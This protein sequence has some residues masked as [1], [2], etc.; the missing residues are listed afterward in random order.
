M[1]TAHKTKNN[2]TNTPTPDRRG[3]NPNRIRKPTGD[4]DF[5]REHIKS[6]PTIESHYC[7][8][9]TKRE[10]LGSHLSVNKMFD[11]Y[12][13]KCAEVDIAPIKN[14]CTIEFLGQNLTWDFTYPKATVATSVKF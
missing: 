13:E 10:Y 14:P 8:A 12:L 1:Y 4:P 7:R 9:N 11:L 3:L 2:K 5:A 6:F